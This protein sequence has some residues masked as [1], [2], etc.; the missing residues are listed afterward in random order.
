LVDLNILSQ[1]S[2]YV[3]RIFR[4]DILVPHQRASRFGDESVDIAHDDPSV[5]KK[6]STCLDFAAGIFGCPRIQRTSAIVSAD[7]TITRVPDRAA[8]RTGLQ[9]GTLS[10]SSFSQPMNAF[11][12]QYR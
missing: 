5:S 8:S 1:R 6:S 3:D 10:C 9:Y 4:T 7:V 11:E 12:S 2:S